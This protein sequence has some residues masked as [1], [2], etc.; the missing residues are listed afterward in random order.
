MYSFKTKATKIFYL[1]PG[2][3]GLKGAFSNG[4]FV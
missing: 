1:S 2:Q 3:K 4:G